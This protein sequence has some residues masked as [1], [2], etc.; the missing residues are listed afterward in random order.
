MDGQRDGGL[1]GTC[2]YWKTDYKRL[3]LEMRKEPR[4]ETKKGIKMKT[5]HLSTRLTEHK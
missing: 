4:R 1:S 5:R 2:F 3:I